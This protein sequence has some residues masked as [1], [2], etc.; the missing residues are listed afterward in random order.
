MRIEKTSVRESEFVRV[1]SVSA[2]VLSGFP[3]F[4]PSLG[5][6]S[7]RILK[8][9]FFAGFVGK[10]TGRIQGNRDFDNSLKTLSSIIFKSH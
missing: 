2:P 9:G 7:H 6:F 3:P 4:Q 8:S 5:E 10:L 1:F